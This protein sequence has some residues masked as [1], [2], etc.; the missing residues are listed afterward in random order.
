MNP[1]RPII[2]LVAVGSDEYREFAEGKGV[3]TVLT[4]MR[5]KRA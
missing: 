4:A 5:N 2:A 3:G 1:T